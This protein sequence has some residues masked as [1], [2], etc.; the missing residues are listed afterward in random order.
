MTLGSTD[1]PLPRAHAGKIPLQ[2]RIPYRQSASTAHVGG[3][4]QGLAY[5][6]KPG[7][8]RMSAQKEEVALKESIMSLSWA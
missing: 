7:P 6:R 8:V 4:R 2:N 5:H 3:W 1:K